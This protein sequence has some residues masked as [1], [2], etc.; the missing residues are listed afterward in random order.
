MLFGTILMLNLALEPAAGPIPCPM[1]WAR[2]NRPRA[3]CFVRCPPADALGK[4]EPAAGRCP[5]ESALALPVEPAA[6]RLLCPMPSG[7]CPGQGGIG[8]GPVALPD[9]LRPIPW[10]RWNRPRAGCLAR[11]PPA[12]ALGKVEPAAGRC[13]GES[14]LA[15]P[16]EP[17]AS[18]L[19][20]PMPSGRCP[21]QG[22][23]GRGPMPWG[24]G[25]CPARGT[26]R[27]PVALPDALRPMPWARW[28]RPRADAQGSR[29]LPCPWNRPRAGCFVRCP[30]ADAL[31]KVE[32]AAGRCPGESA[33]TLPVEP[34]A[35][36]LLCPMPS[37]RCPG[38]GGTGR[39]PMPRGVGTCPARGTGRGP[40]A[41]SDALRPMPWARW[42]RPRADALGIGACPAR[43]TGRKPVALPDALRPMP[44]ARWN[45]P[46][47]DAL[48]SRRL[49]CP[50]N[51]P[52]AGCFA[53]CP[54]A[55]ALGKMEPAAGRCP[56]ESA[57]ALPVEP[58]ARR[59]LCPMPSGRCPGQGGIGRGPMPRGVGT[60][61]ARGTGRGPVAL[62]DALR[63]MPWARWNR[64]RAD[65]QGSRQL[66]LPVE[67]AAGRL[68]CPMPSGRCPG[69][70]GTG[71]GPMPW[72]V[73]ACPARGTGRKPVAL[74]DALRPMPWARWN[75]PRADALGSRALALPV[76]PAAGRLLCPMPSG[77]C[78]GQ[79]GTGRGPMPR[80]VG[81]CPAR[82][83]GRAPV[84][85]S[86]AL[87][88]M[89]WARWNRPRADAQGS[90]RLPC[91]WNRPRAGCFVRCP[92]ADA[93][94]K[95]EP[96]AGRCPGESALALPVEPAAGR[97]LC[98]MP[99]GR[100]PGQGGTGRGPMPRGVGACPARGTG[101][102][103]VALPDALRPM[104]WGVGRLP[105]PWNRPR[106]GCLARCPPADALGSQLPCPW[107]RPR[108]GCLARCPPADAQGKVEPAAG[109]CLGQGGAR[110]K[111]TGRGVL[112]CPC[113]SRRIVVAS[114]PCALAC[115]AARG[116]RVFGRKLDSLCPVSTLRTTPPR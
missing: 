98:P 34:A 2:W 46:R 58:A 95:V 85:L 27:G 84:A 3:G 40:V 68:L 10:A 5:G 73:G 79:D 8:R 57:L 65:A 77:R 75:R 14:A 74:P 21:G 86:D 56:G 18:R 9:A 38:Q 53:R 25:A 104:P 6:G 63:P 1:P 113:K 45:R 69:Q 24:V 11:C 31:G 39:G 67:P 48:G 35:G 26:G 109:R 115:L 96:A 54:P 23:T 42:N 116:L 89:P 111:E 19:L 90:R 17:A 41:L 37:G 64:P 44:W 80:G 110:P 51:R 92:P 12:D 66:A 106:A 70:G 61:P 105:C 103:P 83:T 94:G 93:L 72:G 76:E 30:P 20:C 13:P 71:R 87:R 32:S 52:R 4:V 7:R 50:W 114:G 81:A 100:C 97:L 16:V 15:L 47:A 33:L 49:P 36:R 60:Y 107:N 29:R 101:R 59:L 102:G 108:T 91:P 82:G 43:G 88:P 99:S 22:G 28:N 62:S 78:P 55:D 112:P